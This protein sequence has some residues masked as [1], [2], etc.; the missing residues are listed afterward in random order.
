MEA[1]VANPQLAACSRH[2]QNLLSPTSASGGH[3]A[4]CIYPTKPQHLAPTREHQVHREHICFTV[5]A[6]CRCHCWCRRRR[7]WWVVASCHS[8]CTA[9]RHPAPPC[10]SSFLCPSYRHLHRHPRLPS[11]HLASGRHQLCEPVEPS[12]NSVESMVLD[13]G[14]FARGRYELIA[15]A[16]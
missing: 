12:N 1:K 16:T 8:A 10:P 2:T 4:C 5:S 6:F 15:L 13:V 9:A 7:R 3:P 14:A 11:R